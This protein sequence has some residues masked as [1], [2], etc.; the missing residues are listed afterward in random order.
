MTFSTEQLFIFAM[1]IKTASDLKF[2]V[3]QSGNEPYFFTRETMKFFGDT[4]RNYG[5]RGPITIEAHNGFTDSGKISVY[6]LF[7]RRPVKHNLTDSAYFCA[8][9]FRRVHLKKD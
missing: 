4:M 9:T 3:E 1:K 2:A 6:E 5:V 8:E 7:R